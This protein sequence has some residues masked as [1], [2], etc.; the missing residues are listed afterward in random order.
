MNAL[1]FTFDGA[2]VRAGGEPDATLFAARDVCAVLGITWSGA[3]LAA[4]PA[5]WQGMLKLNTPGG[6]QEVVGITEAAVYKLAFRSN[7]PKAE[8][9]TNWVAS[10]VLPAIRKTGRY[11]AAPV[12]TLDFSDPLTAAKLYIESETGRRAAVQQLA[13]QAPAVAF[14]EKVQ[15]S[16]A[17]IGIGNFAQMIGWGQNRLFKELRRRGILFYRD[18]YNVPKQELIQRGY[19]KVRKTF[20]G[21]FDHVRV[22]LTGKGQL[23]LARILNAQI[24]PM[25]L[26]DAVA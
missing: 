19:F 24:T 18:E 7:K 10:E 5:H 22:M 12:A 21:E 8:A 25:L 14:A 2:Q 9:F 11:E 17:E 23:W 1:I 3:T 26:P 4:I 13:D 6:T 20:T 15:A 16:P